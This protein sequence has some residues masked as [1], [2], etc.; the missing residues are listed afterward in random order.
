MGPE[1]QSPLNNLVKNLFANVRFFIKAS[2]EMAMDKDSHQIK[3]IFWV[4]S[5]LT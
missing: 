4:I 1:I 2:A 3:I 5:E